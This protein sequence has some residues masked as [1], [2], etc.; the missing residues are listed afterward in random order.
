MGRQVSLSGVV[1]PATAW[2][3]R[4]WSCGGVLA[5][6][7]PWTVRLEGKTFDM[8]RCRGPGRAIRKGCP[9]GNKRHYD[10]AI[11]LIHGDIRLDLVPAQTLVELH[12]SGAA[13]QQTQRSVEFSHPLHRSRYQL[14]TH[15]AAS[16]RSMHHYATEPNGLDKISFGCSRF[17]W[18]PTGVTDQTAIMNETDMTA[19]LSPF[20]LEGFSPEGILL[21]VDDDCEVIGAKVRHVHELHEGQPTSAG[22]WPGP[23]GDPDPSTATAGN[24]SETRPSGTGQADDQ[25][26]RWV[27]LLLV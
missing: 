11:R 5:V 21:A 18:N 8:Q 15:T 13:E 12:P 20:D 9:A 22:R 19:L 1:S 16:V 27:G 7:I 23:V 24:F 4:P 26:E 17:N 3:Q 2:S 10:F 25:G 14:P 6:H